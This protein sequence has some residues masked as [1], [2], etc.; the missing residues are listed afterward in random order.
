MSEQEYPESI[1]V[2]ANEMQGDQVIM[3]VEGTLTKLFKPMNNAHGQLQNGDLTDADGNLL[4][5]SFADCPQPMSARGQWI[6]IRSV[7][8]Q[9]HGWT[10]CKVKDDAQYGRSIWVT[11]SALV[12]Y[13][14]GA[15]APDRPAQGGGQRP[16]PAQQRR[17]QSAPRTQAPP[18]RGGG[19]PAPRTQGQKPP[20]TTQR[21]EESQFDQ[22]DRMLSCY[23]YLH[24]LVNEKLTPNLPSDLPPQVVADL[25]SRATATLFVDVAK[26]GIVASWNPKAKH[27]QF[28]PPPRDPHQWQECYIDSPA[29]QL[30]GK[31]LSEISDV[32]LIKLFEYYD[33]KKSNTPLAEC[34]YQAATDRDLLKPAEPETDGSAEDPDGEEPDVPF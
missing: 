15:P 9:S 34:V 1:A 22:I 6:S 2:I 29:S 20:A 31:K 17:P 24:A 26:A 27:H 32:D 30:H 5:I 4:K 18:Q 10:G 28:P 21:R 23:L 16:P 12:E 19:A 3:W 13:P 7:R 8:S 33:G 25:Q 11:P 14:G